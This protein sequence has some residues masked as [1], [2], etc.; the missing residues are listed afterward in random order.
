[1]E[2][3]RILIIDDDPNLRKTLAD[4][5][6][7][8]GY[9]TLAAKDGSEGLALL[10]ENAVNL[11]LVDLGLPDISGL[12][13]LHRVKAGYPSTEVII[14]T[15]NASLDSAIESTNRGAFSYLVKPYE[16][17]QLL[18]HVRRAVEKQQAVTELKSVTDSLWVIFN[19]VYDAIFIHELDGSIIEVND[20]MLE[21]FGINRDEVAL[22][23]IRDDYSAPDNPADQL[24]SKWHDAMSGKAQFFEWKARRPKDGSI[25]DVE[26]FLRKIIFRKKDVI[27]ATVRDISDRKQAETII[28]KMQFQA[29]QREKLA[30]IGQLAAGVAHEINNPMGFINSNLAT[31]KKYTGRLAE[32]IG[33]L[34]INIINNTNAETGK[35][36]E[37]TR[38]L[39]K[40]DHILTDTLTLIEESLEGAERVK[41]IVRNLNSF[42]RVDHAELS[43]IDINESLNNTINIAW[44]QIQYVATLNREFGDIPRIKCFPQQLNQVFLNLLVNAAH[45]IRTKGG[46]HGVINVRT[47]SDNNA[48]LVSIA[49]TGCGIPEE[50]RLRIFEPF[51]TTKDVGKGTGLGLSISYD[52]I[53]KHG[54]EISVDS[55]AGLGTTFIVSLPVDGPKG[56]SSAED[57]LNQYTC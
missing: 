16:I 13:V 41:G 11:A 52:I 37:D 42:A 15:G 9:E 22:Y 50:I 17:D 21:M 54:G 10:G 3:A 20:K 32:F 30:T 29:I 19:S 55:E 6:R 24:P 45:A 43:I 51:F 48:I 40:I 7:V 38:K 12:E 2:R 25:F 8:K 56:Q 14:L 46:E 5:L 57:N 34:S 26:I 1:M 39:M 44:N 31:L 33:H 35:Q 18:L 36:V 49:D 23:S 27:M 4:I 28:K 53:R 47:W